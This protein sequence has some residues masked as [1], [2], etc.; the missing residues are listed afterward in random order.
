[1]EQEY[2]LSPLESGRTQ[3]GEVRVLNE[4]GDLGLEAATCE[5][6]E[7]DRR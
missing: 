2:R 7:K 6:E 3:G 1:M 4:G 5:T